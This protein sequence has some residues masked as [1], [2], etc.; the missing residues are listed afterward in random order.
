MSDGPDLG[1]LLAELRNNWE[2]AME[3]MANEDEAGVEF[4]L[5]LMYDA[6]GEYLYEAPGD[7]EGAD[8]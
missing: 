4:Y 1:V 8:E 7:A 2:M 5:A 3:D 6:I